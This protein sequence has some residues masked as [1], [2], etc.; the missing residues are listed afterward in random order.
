VAQL[1]V[2]FDLGLVAGALV[3]I[4]LRHVY[5]AGSGRRLA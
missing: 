1:G 3:L 5:R 4:T 2:K